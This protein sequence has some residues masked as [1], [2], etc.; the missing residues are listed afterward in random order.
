MRRVRESYIL[1]LTKNIREKCYEIQRLQVPWDKVSNIVDP[2]YNLE[3]PT[4]NVE[5]TFY[6]Q[7]KEV[8]TKLSSEIDSLLIY[9]T[10][11]YD[12]I[13]LKIIDN[14]L[15]S[16]IANIRKDDEGLKS[17]NA[18]LDNNSEYHYIEN[19]QHSLF[20]LELVLIQNSKISL[21][22]KSVTHKNTTFSLRNCIF[23]QIC[24]LRSIIYIFSKN[25]CDER[26]RMKRTFNSSDFDELK[27]MGIIP[28]LKTI[29][30]TFTN[31][32]DSLWMKVLSLN[33][34]NNN[35]NSS[36]ISSI[37][38]GKDN[39]KLI[40]NGTAKY[41]FKFTNNSNNSS[42]SSNI[43]KIQ[44]SGF[45][46]VDELKEQP[47][48]ILL[49]SLFDLE[50]S[51]R[52]LL[53][54]WKSINYHIKLEKYVNLLLTRV[55]M[56]ITFNF[57]VENLYN[58]NIRSEFINLNETISEHDYCYKM[59]IKI[60]HIIEKLHRFNTFRTLVNIK[61]LD[62]DYSSIHRLMVINLKSWCN[63]WVNNQN[64]KFYMDMVRKRHL[65]LQLPPGDDEWL[66]Y[67]FPFE[68]L[69]HNTIFE[70]LHCSIFPIISENA[71]MPINDILTLKHSFLS[72]LHDEIVI[73]A[74]DLLFLGFENYSFSK[75]YYYNENSETRLITKHYKINHP[76]LA[77][78]FS[79]I[80][81]HVQDL[82]LI[83][84]SSTKYETIKTS[85]LKIYDSDDRL[86]YKDLILYCVTNDNTI[87]ESI[88]TLI[89]LL[90]KLNTNN[91]NSQPTTHEADDGS[92]QFI[93]YMYDKLINLNKT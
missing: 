63:E 4:K 9:L 50:E 55:S 1:G 81:V 67:A 40:T 54:R 29:N 20:L 21:T 73:T 69:T 91:N 74:V 28:T 6:I 58:K 18:H 26:I 36:S 10:I 84:N 51:F 23:I 68:P 93:N 13:D 34:N 61:H 66:S 39:T 27:S 33:N 53:Y 30:Q 46:I 87:Y 45:D 42:N 5:L 14:N 56:I 48:L 71:N 22:W 70:K 37:R 52:F 59:C 43:S 75:Q 17:I 57:R 65:E 25:E 35:N 19:L 72:K 76:F 31:E 32:N 89:L 24:R 80:L 8:Y 15:K 88:A 85:N 82:T 90:K 44:K 60:Y 12:C 64:S 47:K 79:K 16:D 41:S 49:Y 77:V 2:I 78:L 86:K 62:N 7:F 3:P 11:D 92:S 38:S 83:D